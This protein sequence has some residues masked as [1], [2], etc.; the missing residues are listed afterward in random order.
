[1]EEQ[2]L[3]K[4]INLKEKLDGYRRLLKFAMNTSV[5]LSVELFENEVNGE[6]FTMNRVLGEEG[7]AEIKEKIISNIKDKIHSLESQIEKL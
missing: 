1:M 2:D 3:E 6:V 5:E 4:A 7:F